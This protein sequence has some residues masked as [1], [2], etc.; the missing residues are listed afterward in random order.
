MR[1]RNSRASHMMR[2]A[3]KVA[4][5]GCTLPGTMMGTELTLLYLKQWRKEYSALCFG[6]LS[7]LFSMLELN[8]MDA[9][10]NQFATESE[11]H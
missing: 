6:I 8:R 5:D 10:K 7:L 2:S 1:K 3:F 11:T 9:A 4:V